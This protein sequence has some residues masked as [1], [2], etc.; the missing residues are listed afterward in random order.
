M[1]EYQYACTWPQWGGC[2]VLSPFFFLMEW[3]T[4]LLR[5]LRKKSIDSSNAIWLMQIIFPGILVCIRTTAQN[6]QQ[7]WIPQLPD[8]K[9]MIV[10]HIFDIFCYTSVFWLPLF[11]CYAVM[12]M[13]CV[14]LDRN[15]DFFLLLIH[16]MLFMVISNQ[17]I[18]WLPVPAMWR[19][20]I[21]VLARFLRWFLYSCNS[22]NLVCFFV[23][24]NVFVLF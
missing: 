22:Y 6:S 7:K 1:N 10:Y 21:S 17:T 11:L 2:F 19:L 5:F 13:L 8:F 12:S 20:G 14:C 4:A 23:L 18:S 3:N 15:T 16:R 9:L 24:A